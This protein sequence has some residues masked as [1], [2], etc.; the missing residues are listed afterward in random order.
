MSPNEYRNLSLWHDT[1][2]EPLEP[3]PRLRADEQVDVVIVGAG[4]TGLW[5]AYYLTELQPGI[6]IAVLES[7]IAGFGASGRNG[8]WCLGTMAGIGQL[9]DDPAQRDGG[10]RLQRALL[11]TPDEVAR[12]CGREAIDCQWMKSGNVTVATS[13]PFLEKVRQELT[14]WRALG[15]SE[16]EVRWMDADECA[17]HVRTAR[18][19]G[20]VYLAEVAALH[21]LR[22]VRGLAEAVERRGV[23]I[24]ERSPALSLGPRCVTTAAGKVTADIVVRATEGYTRTLPGQER[25]LIPVHSM[26]VATEP[27]GQSIWDEI[28]FVDRITFGDPRRMVTYGQRTA[29]DRM[30]F[31]CR[32]AYYFGSKIRD[33]FSPGDPLFA[34]VREVLDSFFPALRDQLV[35]HRWGGALGVPRNWRPAVGLDRQAGL[36]WGGGYVGEGVGASNLVGRI[37]ADLILERETDLVD[38]PLV[39]P[40][41]SNWEPEPLRWIGSTVL[42]KIGAALDNAEIHDRPPPRIRNAIFETLVRK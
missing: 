5:V 25:A 19:Y 11:N 14:D 6:R 36:A 32:G 16:D 8:G 20:G 7:E 40:D 18:N 23:S 4:F 2:P 28:G 12:V 42:M 26:M 3:R 27:L 9:L 1:V 35:T 38:L 22:L 39:G 13:K 33:R 34:Q 10:I 41:F 21:P 37:L 31:G 17:A 30:A 29:D 24:Y 15:A